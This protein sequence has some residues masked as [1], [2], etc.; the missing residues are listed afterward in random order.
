ME[1]TWQTT[2]KVDYGALVTELFANNTL[3]LHLY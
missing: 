2:K 1:I 3:L